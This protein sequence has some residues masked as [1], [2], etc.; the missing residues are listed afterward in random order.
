[1][2]YYTLYL[3]K[4]TY[5]ITSEYKKGPSSLPFERDEY[6]KPSEH[7]LRL[8]VELVVDEDSVFVTTERSAETFESCV[9]EKLIR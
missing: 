6:Y 4:G 3:P 1:M 9:I 7:R 2:G 5:R 8:P